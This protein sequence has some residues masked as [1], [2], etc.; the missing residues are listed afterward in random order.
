MIT[1]ICEVEGECVHFVLHNACS[2]LFVMEKIAKYLQRP[3]KP[4]LLSTENTDLCSERKFTQKKTL[5]T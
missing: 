3:G 4:T 1:R 5:E 2:S